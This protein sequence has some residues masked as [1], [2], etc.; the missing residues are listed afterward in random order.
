MKKIMKLRMLK[1]YDGVPIDREMLRSHD[2]RYVRGPRSMPDSLER[3]IEEL[4]PE[5]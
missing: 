3:E 1:K 5:K 2:V 4:Y